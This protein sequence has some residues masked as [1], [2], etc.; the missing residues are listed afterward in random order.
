M[1]PVQ[2][3]LDD[4]RRLALGVALRPI[5]RDPLLPPLA[6]AVAV[7]VDH[8]GPGA[9]ASLANMA[10]YLRSPLHA[11]PKKPVARPPV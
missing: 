3:L 9:V 11:E 1:N 5:D 10:P 8:D 2:R 6:V 4:L 7:Q